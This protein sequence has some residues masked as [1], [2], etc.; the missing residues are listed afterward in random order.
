MV[1]GPP[2]APLL[3]S[4]AAMPAS[5]AEDGAV[6]AVAVPPAGAVALRAI[7]TWPLVMVNGSGLDVPP[8]GAGLTTVTSVLTRSPRAARSVAV[9]VARSSVLLMK[10]VGRSTPSQRTVEP[11]VKLL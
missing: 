8:A 3:F 4:V 7:L 6:E 2:A 9:I 11:L 1:A 5:P 10:V